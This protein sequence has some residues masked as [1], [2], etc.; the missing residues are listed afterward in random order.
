[1]A[2]SAALNAPFSCGTIAGTRGGPTFDK[3]RIAEFVLSATPITRITSAA[4]TSTVTIQDATYTRTTPTQTITD[5]RVQ[6]QYSDTGAYF[7]VTITSGNTGVIGSPVNDVA[8]AVSPGTAR[9]TGAATGKISVVKDVT[10]QATTYLG[11]V[12]TFSAFV[13]GSAGKNM[14]DSLYS[15]ATGSGTTNMYSAVDT[16]SSPYTFTRSSTVWTGDWDTSCISPYSNYGAQG[17]TATLISP[18]H[19]VMATHYR[20]VVGT[21]VRF[22]AMNNAVVDRTITGIVDIAGTDISIGLLDTAVPGSINFA[23]VLGPTTL[24]TYIPAVGRGY[25]LI[26]LTTRYGKPALVTAVQVG[27]TTFSVSTPP[28]A[29]ISR[30]QAIVKGDSGNPTFLVLGGQLVLIGLYTSPNT[31]YHIGGNATAV[32]AAM[33]S[34]G[35]GYALTVVNLSAYTAF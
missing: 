13:S 4:G 6:A 1:M 12:D 22:I 28:P 20:L 21:V 23:R 32:N 25:G 19:V 10:V 33:S 34:L 9:F 7:P 14:A 24:S 11:T 17:I 26:G 5:Y 8:T 29:Y 31:G 27:L 35:G 15:R 30:V 18:R 16:S 2:L 3:G